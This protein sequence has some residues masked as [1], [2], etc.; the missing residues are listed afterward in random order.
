[1][2]VKPSTLE[3]LGWVACWDAQGKNPIKEGDTFKVTPGSTID[4]CYVCKPEQHE[5]GKWYSNR[6]FIH[7]P[8][9][10]VIGGV[11]RKERIVNTSFVCGDG[12]PTG[13][14]DGRLE[15]IA[16]WG[17][18]IGV[19]G[20]INYQT[21]KTSMF[22]TPPSAMYESEQEA[23]DDKLYFYY[24]FSDS[25]QVIQNFTSDGG[26]AVKSGF[27]EIG[28]GKT[29]NSTIMH[30]GDENIRIEQHHSETS[31]SFNIRFF[32]EEYK[33]FV[34]YS[35]KNTF[36]IRYD[37]SNETFYVECFPYIGN[38]VTY[39]IEVPN[40]GIHKWHDFGLDYSDGVLS[41]VINGEK[42][43]EHRPNIAIGGVE[44]L[45]LDLSNV[46]SIELYGVYDG[47]ALKSNDSNAN[48]VIGVS[49]DPETN[50]Q[51]VKQET[52]YFNSGTEN[53]F[54]LLF[55]RKERR[56]ALMTWASTDYIPDVNVI[57]PVTDR[58]SLDVLAN[59]GAYLVICNGATKYW[60]F[61]W[62][63]AE[64][65]DGRFFVK[66]TGQ[67]SGS[68]Y[69]CCCSYPSRVY[70]HN[71][72]Y[73]GSTI[74]I[75]VKFKNQLTSEE[76]VFPMITLFPGS[77]VKVDAMEMDPDLPLKIKQDIINSGNWGYY[78]GDG[79]KPGFRNTS[80]RTLIVR[81]PNTSSF[82][83]VWNGYICYRSGDNV[84]QTSY[85]S[86]Y[87]KITRNDSANPGFSIE[88]PR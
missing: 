62:K 16:Y 32:F 83:L 44:S 58:V 20:L 24:N 72:L 22:G 26:V 54:N 11:Y 87:R 13:A 86:Y 85:D 17:R 25:T 38:S 33:D 36:D 52:L 35:N 37:A 55:D 69:T 63:I 42:L 66:N 81:I 30:G 65:S 27:F 14:I 84:Y 47:L 1:M 51:G 64:D 79:N 8:V 28:A 49:V 9:P 34:L 19:A 70:W 43:E 88:V 18:S 5:N 53:A 59:G 68:T 3:E 61:W 46:E 41:I 12:T 80:G 57:D 7:K 6:L 75:R 48:S 77:Q 71:F 50:E 21:N 10:G 23:I 78:N 60:D 40:F 67:R 82:T 74:R 29:T 39:A 56:T 2:I 15:E 45:I 76:P 73:A 31:V 4:V